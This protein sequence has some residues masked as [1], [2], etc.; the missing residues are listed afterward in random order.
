[1]GHDDITER[2]RDAI[3]SYHNF[4]KKGIIF[5]DLLP[6]LRKPELFDDLTDY[7]CDKIHE[8]VP[9]VKAVVGLEARGFLL[10]PVIALK[11]KVPFVPI[12]KVGKLP[13]SVRKVSYSLEYGMD[14]FEIQTEA[15]NYGEEVIIIDDLLAS[16]GT[17]Q[18]AVQ[19]L[20][21]CGV[22]VAESLVIIELTEL[23]GRE[24]ISVP[25]FSV[26]QI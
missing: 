17:M 16:G 26:L 14:S 11:L 22:I 23:N 21:D 20:Q 1:M 8:K 6:V 18:A 24:K 25:F 3:Q 12:R 7:L 19:L 13:G 2:V 15:L 10:G 9:G 4:P 5:R